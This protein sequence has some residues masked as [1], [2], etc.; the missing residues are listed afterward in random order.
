M[1]FMQMILKLLKKM[2]E[3]MN[4]NKT[5]CKFWMHGPTAVIE[6]EAGI[7]QGREH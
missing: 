1:T 4:R 6:L 7:I 5:G 3:L 2:T